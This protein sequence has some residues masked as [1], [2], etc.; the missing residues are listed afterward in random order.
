[1]IEWYAL[2]ACLN[3][4][5]GHFDWRKWAGTVFSEGAILPNLSES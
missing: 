3:I 5:F 4:Y 2:F 1:M